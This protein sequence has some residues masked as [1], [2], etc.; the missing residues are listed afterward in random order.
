MLRARGAL[1]IE[2]HGHYNRRMS[3][4]ARAPLR[5]I[6]LENSW[7]NVHPDVI[8][9]PQPFA[10]YPYWM[11][12]TPYPLLDDRVE[13]PTIRASHDGMH[14]DRIPG[15]PDPLVSAPSNQETHHADAELLSVEDRLC[16]IYLT[17]NKRTNETTFNMISCGPDLQW[18]KP[19]VIYE[20]VGAVS[21]AFQTEGDTFHVWFVRMKEKDSSRSELLHREGPGLLSLGQ[22]T[23]CHLDIPGYVPWH[24]DVLKV[25]T[26]Y[27]A[28]VTAF[29]RGTDNSRS[30]LFHVISEDGLEFTL[31]NKTAIIRPSFVG[32]D[33]RV[34]HRSTFLK[35]PDGTYRIWYSAG[36]WGFHFGIGLL[37]GSLDSLKDPL[38]GLASVPS[39]VRR[40]PGDVKGR[41][42]YEARS[43]RSRF[44]KS[45]V[46]EQASF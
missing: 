25:E 32:W 3:L 45:L 19:V 39:Y 6:G 24:L 8:H 29:P 36:S 1:P 11:V 23:T 43:L 33:N 28:L 40:L 34:I 16:V 12:F 37:Q 14:W 15:I 5:I 26:G 42:R 38:V 41:L 35:D 20:D 10:G 44:R 30:S 17:I 2:P 22:E 27:E 46:N 4:N 7:E 31:S 18:S 9:M 21:P 13:N